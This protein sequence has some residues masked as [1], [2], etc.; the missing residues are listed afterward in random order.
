MNAVEWFNRV[1]GSSLQS[2]M[3]HPLHVS[4]LVFSICMISAS[5]AEIPHWMHQTPADDELSTM[6]ASPGEKHDSMDLYEKR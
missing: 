3:N 1:A 5:L 2:E 6:M 4:V